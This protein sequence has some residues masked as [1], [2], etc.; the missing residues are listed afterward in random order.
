MI[1]EYSRNMLS[2]LLLNNMLSTY[3]GV[4]TSTKHSAKPWSSYA[5]FGLLPINKTGCR[6]LLWERRRQFFWKKKGER[7]KVSL[8][9]KRDLSS[10]GLIDFNH[11]FLSFPGLIVSNSALILSCIVCLIA[12]TQLIR[13][14]SIIP[15]SCSSAS[16]VRETGLNWLLKVLR[17]LAKIM[18]KQTKLVK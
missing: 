17:M 4:V 10:A 15:F 9:I 2:Q 1:L 5:C 14:Y 18:S 8:F 13:V 6:V 3:Q 7:V 11:W 12:A 16:Q